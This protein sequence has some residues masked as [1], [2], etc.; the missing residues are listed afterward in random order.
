M[1]YT[2]MERYWLVD[3]DWGGHKFPKKLFIDNR[4]LKLLFFAPNLVHIS[5]NILIILFDRKLVLKLVWFNIF[6]ITTQGE[7]N[8]RPVVYVE[9]LGTFMSD[10]VIGLG[11]RRQKLVENDHLGYV[12]A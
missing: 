9:N 1:F 10:S 2:L 7:L 11:T 4:V 12:A 3:L 5:Q 6:C 8:L